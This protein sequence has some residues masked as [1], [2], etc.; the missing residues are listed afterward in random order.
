MTTFSRFIATAVEKAEEQLYQQ[1]ALIPTGG[2]RKQLLNLL[3]L[4]GTPV[5]GATIKMYILRT[6]LVDDSHK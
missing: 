2:E 1:L 5:Y 6:P 3:E 4:V